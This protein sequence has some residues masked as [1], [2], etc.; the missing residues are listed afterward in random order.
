[1]SIGGSGFMGLR[2]VLYGV[3]VVDGGYLMFQVPVAYVD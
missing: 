1:M 2:Y 3:E